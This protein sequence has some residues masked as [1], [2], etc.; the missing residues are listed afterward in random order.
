MLFYYLQ[1]TPVSI[2]LLSGFMFHQPRFGNMSLQSSSLLFLR[3]T[4][5]KCISIRSSKANL[6]ILISE[7]DSISD[8]KKKT[9]ILSQA[10]N[11]NDGKNKMGNIIKFETLINVYAYMLVYY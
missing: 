2:V 4:K 5:K 7:A 6:T 11:N 8:N 10:L 1:F 9:T 3:P